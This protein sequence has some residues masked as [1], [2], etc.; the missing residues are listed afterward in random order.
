MDLMKE[1]C[2]IAVALV[3]LAGEDMEKDD[4]I[5]VSFE[6]NGK[7]YN[8]CITVCDLGGADDENSV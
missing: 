7:K 2:K 6:S 5:T 3:E 8:V 1:F 4:N